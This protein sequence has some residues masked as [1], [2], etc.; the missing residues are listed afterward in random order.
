[1]LW[2]AGGSWNHDPPRTSTS[3]M[4]IAPPRETSFRSKAWLWLLLPVCAVLAVLAMF[5][6]HDGQTLDRIQT[7]LGPQPPPASNPVSVAALTHGPI[8]LRP[9]SND[10]PRNSDDLPAAPHQESARGPLSL[11]DQPF[12]APGTAQSVNPPVL[13]M[14]AADLHGAE[15]SNLDYRNANLDNADLTDTRLR[16]VDLSNSRLSH[17]HWYSALVETTLFRGAIMRDADIRGSHFFRAD[18][19]G[20]DLRNLNAAPSDV[21]ERGISY[22]TALHGND[23]RDA[24]LRGADLSAAGLWSADFRGADLRGANFEGASTR[25][26]RC[27]G[28]SLCPSAKWRGAIYD[29]ATR[30]NA[31]FDPAEEGMVLKSRRTSGDDMATTSTSAIR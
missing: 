19:R 23:F 3:H 28:F 14:Q 29:E 12:D 7:Q 25:D 31:G 24:D 1:M 8:P 22:G 18:F 10:S 27:I 30:F 21:D 6:N 20:A 2:E 15:L 16:D 11:V 17:T 26:R 5:F 13:D 4:T 9:P